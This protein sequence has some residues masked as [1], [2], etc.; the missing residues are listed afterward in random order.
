MKF[1]RSQLARAISLSLTGTAVVG[2]VVTPAQAIRN[3]ADYLVVG[4]PIRDAQD[5]AEAA[6]RIVDEIAAATT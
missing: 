3:G 1:K 4:R 2:T 6:Q 5:P